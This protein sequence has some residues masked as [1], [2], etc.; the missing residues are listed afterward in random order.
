MRRTPSLPV[1]FILLA[2]LMA[3]ALAAGLA[4][5]RLDGAG[6]PAGASRAGGEVGVA[7]GVSIGGPYVLTAQDGSRMGSAD[8]QGDFQLSYFGITYCPDVCPTELAS[9]ANA[10]D[11]MGE[12][13]A[14]VRPVFITVDP[15][16]DDPSTMADYVRHFH[17]RLIGLTGTPDEIGAVLK[18][19]RVFARKVESQTSNQYVMD[20][21]TFVYLMGPDG[22]FLS[23]FRYGTDPEEMAR[24]I[25][26]HVDAAS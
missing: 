7:A 25:A 14:R 18:S 20:H 26:T 11:R 3:I 5:M 15:E 17:P 24:A 9:L 8:F 22:Q 1:L 13:A 10:L 12:K 4:W 19:F 21:S 6:G 23:M 16:R 2:A